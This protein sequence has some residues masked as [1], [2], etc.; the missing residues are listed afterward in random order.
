MWCED[1][2][3]GGNAGL[4]KIHLMESQ[5]DDRETFLMSSSLSASGSFKNLTA[6]EEWK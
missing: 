3:E 5:N 2:A 6:L 1:N 4:L